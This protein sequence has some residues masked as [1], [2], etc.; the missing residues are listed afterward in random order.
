MTSPADFVVGFNAD[1]VQQSRGRTLRV[2]QFGSIFQLLCAT[3]VGVFAFVLLFLYWP[4]GIVALSTFAI[5]LW[6]AVR[7]LRKVQNL[8]KAW[9]DHGVP[10]V[11]MRLSAAGLD[12][13]LDAPADRV[14]LP[15]STITGFRLHQ[16]LGQ[17]MLIVDL[18]N[19]VD[20]NTPGTQGLNHPDVQRAMKKPMHGTRG[21]HT[22]LK[23]LDQPSTAIDTAARHFTAGRVGIAQSSPGIGSPR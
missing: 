21:L 2:L 1:V 20:A 8:R 3:A 5:I 19:G 6:D 23:V 10:S 14:F 7:R 4:V 22:A 16:W 17:D 15:W 13:S 11:A 18:A 9:L 12:M